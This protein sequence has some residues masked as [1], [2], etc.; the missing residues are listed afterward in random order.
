M[1]KKIIMPD[2]KKVLTPGEGP[3]PHPFEVLTNNQQSLAFNQKQILLN[4]RDMVQML[5]VIAKQVRVEFP[6]EEASD[7][8]KTS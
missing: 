5:I 3:A 1:D 6:K 8:S 7:D 2:E 4:Q